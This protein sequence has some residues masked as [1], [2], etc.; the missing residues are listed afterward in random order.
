MKK[1]INQRH[2]SY[3]QAIIK[4]PDGYSLNVE[5]SN[6]MPNILIKKK[7]LHHSDTRPTSRS[8]GFKA[9]MTL[10]T[11]FYM[12]VSKNGDKLLGLYIQ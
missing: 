2:K 3:H 11:S 6:G 4:I 10:A 12:V 9:Q 5:L 8:N 1:W 7:K